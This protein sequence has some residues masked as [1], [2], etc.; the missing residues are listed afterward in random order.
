MSVTRSSGGAAP[1]EHIVTFQAP[2]E[3]SFHEK[4]LRRFS[5]S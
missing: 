3:T 5:I 4:V 1:Y 2:P